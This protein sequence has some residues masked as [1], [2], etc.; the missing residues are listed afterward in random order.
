MILWTGFQGSVNPLKLC[1]KLYVHLREAICFHQSLKDGLKPKQGYR[2]TLW[3]ISIPHGHG[4]YC[5]ELTLDQHRTRWK[6]RAGRWKNVGVSSVGIEKKKQEW[7]G[8]FPKVTA[9][10]K[11]QIRWSHGWGGCS[12][13]PLACWNHM[14]VDESSILSPLPI[15]QAVREDNLCYTL[16][17]IKCCSSLQRE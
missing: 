16:S 9:G 13:Q 3:D 12:S 4:R 8:T 2:P 17:H 6:L 1:T 7:G 11:W 10:K 14:Y 5:S 15:I